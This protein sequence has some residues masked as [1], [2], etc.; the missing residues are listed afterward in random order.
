V[1][2]RAAMHDAS[3]HVTPIF[4]AEA[5]GYSTCLVAMRVPEGRL[6]EAAKAVNAHPGVSHNYRRTRAFNM[7]FTIAVPPGSDLQ[8]HSTPSVR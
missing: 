6:A 1:I 3:S 8:A 5:L 2:A 7:W 4:D